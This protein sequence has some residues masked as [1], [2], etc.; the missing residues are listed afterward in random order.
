MLYDP[1]SLLLLHFCITYLSPPSTLSIVPLLHL[2]RSFTCLL[3]LCHLAT[4][5]DV[6]VSNR[7]QREPP[8]YRSASSSW[9]LVQQHP[10]ASLDSRLLTPLMT[11]NA[12]PS[13]KSHDA[14]PGVP[15]FPLAGP[16]SCQGDH[17]CKIRKL[18]PHPT[19][20]SSRRLNR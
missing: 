11:E 8:R 4:K 13:T 1:V 16:S 3:S 7:R 17:H 19:E 12:P 14:R 5:T 10:A 2:R 20:L 15:S 6:G 9:R 18:L